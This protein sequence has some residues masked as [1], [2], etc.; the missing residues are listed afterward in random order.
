MAGETPVKS[1]TIKS[2]LDDGSGVLKRA[3]IES[4]RREA[5]L[6][7]EHATG[8]SAITLLGYPE[9][10]VENPLAFEALIRRRA[11]REP[12]SHL[13]GQREFWSMAFKVTADTL[14]PRPDSETVIEAV[15]GAFRD[16]PAPVRIL[17][18]GVG[19]GCLLLALLSEF[20]TAVGVGVDLSLAAAKVA[21]EN[22]ITLGF[23][24]DRSGRERRA[25]FSVG[26]WGDAI[27]G[28][29]DLVVSNPPYIP[30]AD[31]DGLEIEVAQFEPRLALAG[32]EDGLVAYREIMPALRD[33]LTPEG[34]A[35]LEFGDGQADSVAALAR[36]AG[37]TVTSVH[38]DLAQRDR[39]LICQK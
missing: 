2:C 30:N 34:V 22:S 8:F 4:P 26:R 38:A 20:P 27:A 36:A 12:M 1:T 35:V 16:K 13:L 17:D 19:T 6:L 23:G 32:G 31:I 10:I 7:L 25:I 15:L 39:C 21:T 3:Q 28:K 11:D 5:R 37:L 9:R 14:D 29:F 33:L 18:L 24:G